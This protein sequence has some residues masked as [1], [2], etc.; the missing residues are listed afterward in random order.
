MFS[1]CA[2]N[3]QVS[4]IKALED[5]KYEIASADSITIANIDVR[6]FLGKEEIDLG[7]MPRLAFAFLRKNVPLK[8]RL[9][10]SISNPS[11]RL[12]AINQFEYKVLIKNRELAGGFVNQKVFIS[13]N[14]GS[15]MVP[16]QINSNVYEVLSDDKVRDAVTDFFIGA[17]DNRKENKGVLTIKIKPTLDLGNR[18]IKYPGYITIDKEISSKN[19]F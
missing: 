10:L 2:I 4:Q 15:T 5:C 7:K 3:K 12:A 9:N 18:Q 19:L 16:I 8:A 17:E 14:G 11:N 1:A 6:K 13:P